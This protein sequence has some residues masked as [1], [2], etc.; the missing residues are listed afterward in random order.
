VIPETWNNVH[1]QNDEV[2]KKSWPLVM[3]KHQIYSQI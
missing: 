3:L 1:E 2:Q